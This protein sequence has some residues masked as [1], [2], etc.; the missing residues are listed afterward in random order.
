MALPSGFRVTPLAQS[1]GSWPGVF[2]VSLMSL[3]PD[4]GSHGTE[5]RVT[6]GVFAG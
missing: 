5:S 2:Q 4:L 3:G 6:L 1:R